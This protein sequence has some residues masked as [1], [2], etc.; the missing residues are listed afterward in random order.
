MKNILIFT[1]LLGALYSQSGSIECWGYNDFGQSSPPAGT[2]TNVDAET[3]HTC[4]LDESG[5]ILCWGRNSFAESSPPE[6][7]F[8]DVS[9]GYYHSCAINASGSI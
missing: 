1:M 4:A 7:T 3:S 8:T 6:G 2:F 5:S 9:A